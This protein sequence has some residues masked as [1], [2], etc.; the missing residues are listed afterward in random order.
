MKRESRIAMAFGVSHR[1]WTI[2]KISVKNT[3]CLYSNLPQIACAISSE[4][5]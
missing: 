3:R 5:R 2:M 4:G 1:H